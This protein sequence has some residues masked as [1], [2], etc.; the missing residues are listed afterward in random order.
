MNKRIKKKHLANQL[1]ELFNKIE[2]APA[3]GAI[4]FHTRMSGKSIESV[5]DIIE[6]MR[7]LQNEL[8]THNVSAVFMPTELLRAECHTDKADAIQALL[9]TL[10]YFQEEE[11]KNVR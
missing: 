4:I 6:N 1:A 2:Y 7:S 9:H 11:N 8:N 10:K 5:A 3:G